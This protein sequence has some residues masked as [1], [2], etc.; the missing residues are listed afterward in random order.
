MAGSHHTGRRSWRPSTVRGRNMVS[1]LDGRRQAEADLRRVLY[2]RPYGYGFHVVKNLCNDEEYVVADGLGFKRTFAPG[3]V[4]MLGSQ[5]GHPG[6][7][8]ISGP[9]SGMGGASAFPVTSAVRSGYGPTPEPPPEPPPALIDWGGLGYIG[10]SGVVLDGVSTPRTWT[11]T[12]MAFDLTGA[13]EGV[14]GSIV[15]A[16]TN[17]LGTT[18]SLHN[19]GSI[20]TLIHGTEPVLAWC[21]NYDKKV[22]LWNLSDA[23]VTVVD[24]QTYTAEPWF[25][26]RNGFSFGGYYYWMEIVRSGGTYPVG[27]YPYDQVLSICRCNASGSAETLVSWSATFTTGDGHTNHR[28]F[29]DHCLVKYADPS[30]GAIKYRKLLFSGTESEVSVTVGSSTLS[31]ENF[32]PLDA[33]TAWA[34]NASTGADNQIYKH[35]ISGSTYSVTDL[36]G[37]VSDAAAGLT[38]LSCNAARTEICQYDI[39]PTGSPGVGSTFQVSRS[40]PGDPFDQISGSDGAGT[41]ASLVHL[42]NFAGSY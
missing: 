1:M 28:W 41:V 35:T 21:S 19:E 7:M 31:W 2:V 20:Q 22:R 17:T 14:G 40:A 37:V 32:I 34:Q 33:T 39:D 27:A 38:A 11:V 12:P 16:S 15:V 30:T 4:V 42:V 3:T 9:P 18:E 10:L 29:T 8:L 24:A 23:T 36:T 26:F 5:T 13:Y 25:V 6:E